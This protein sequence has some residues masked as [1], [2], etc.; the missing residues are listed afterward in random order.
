MRFAHADLMLG[1]QTLQCEGLWQTFKACRWSAASSLQHSC[2]AASS[3]QH[4]W[5]GRRPQRVPIQSRP[6]PVR[7]RQ[8]RPC[9]HCTQSPAHTRPLQP[10]DTRTGAQLRLNWQ[11]GGRD[12]AAGTPRCWLTPLWGGGHF[13]ASVKI[14]GSARQL[15]LAVHLKPCGTMG[16]HP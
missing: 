6:S 12:C 3:L 14:G 16:R 8:C 5:S 9:C 13:C 4:G 7:A 15:C 11:E 10:G 2:A 1:S